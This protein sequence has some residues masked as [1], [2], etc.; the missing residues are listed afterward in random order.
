MLVTAETVTDEQIRELMRTR[1]MGDLKLD[2][3]YR[4]ALDRTH[5]NR[6]RDRERCAEI[7]NARHGGSDAR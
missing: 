2:A 5:V 7:W 6:V 3:V 4:R 1:P